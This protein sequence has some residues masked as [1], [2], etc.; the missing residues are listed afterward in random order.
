MMQLPHSEFIAVGA[1]KGWSGFV[2]MLKI[3]IPISFL[4][5][6]LQYSGVLGKID[7]LLEPAM[8]F[9]NLPAMA[10]FPL[11]V[12]LLAGIYGAIATMAALPLTDGQMTLITVFL[13][14]S[15][16]LV[17]EGIIQGKSGINPFLATLFRL[18]ASVVTVLVVMQ[19]IDTDPAETQDK[20]SV[21]FER[22]SF[23][24][25]LQNWGIATAYLCLKMLV[26]ICALMILLEAMKTYNLVS[27]LVNLLNPIL[28]LLGLTSR[29]GILW[30]TAVFFGIA[31]G[32]A[33]IVEETKGSDLSR[34]ELM[35]LHLSIGI[36][37][38]IIEDPAVF[39]SLGL[40]PLWLWIPRIVASI[41]F[42]HLLAFIIKSA[43][44]LG[45]PLI[46]PSSETEN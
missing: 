33:V 24:H 4:T 37:H 34:E 6:L 21:L 25:T 3:L 31:Y 16:N 43:E 11:L 1:K 42:V 28:K 30:V 7:F 14:I 20:L 39:L 40:N 26:I 2:W 38:A 18:A 13:L 23:G 19:F 17:Q 29:V 9:M 36:N 27:F 45:M 8:A 5:T 41:V 10:A 32:G 46:K 12:G 15:H 44:L 35:K 22:A